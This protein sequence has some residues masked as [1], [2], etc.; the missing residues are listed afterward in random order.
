MTET[1]VRKVTAG[2]LLLAVG[3]VIIF[4]PGVLSSSVPAAVVALGAL[5]LAAGA[6]LLGSSDDGTRPV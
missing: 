1:D 6:L 5:G 2:A 4:G 3:T